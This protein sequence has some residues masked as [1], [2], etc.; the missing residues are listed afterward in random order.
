MPAEPQ[1]PQPPLR[2]QPPKPDA[3]ADL[4]GTP[5]WSERL[6]GPALV[7]FWGDD[8]PQS[9]FRLG[10]REYDWHTHARGQLFCID[11]GLAQLHTPHGSWVLPAHRA[12]WIPPGTA[13]KASVSGALSGWG[14][15]LTPQACRHLPEHPCVFGVSE[16][17]RALVRRA[18]AWQGQQA[19]QRATPAQRRLVGVLLDEI[20]QAPQEALHLPMPQD[21][22]L[23]RLAQA[24]LAAPDAHPTLAA[25]AAQVGLSERS[26][27]RLFHSE[28]GLSFAHWRQQAQL[29]L[30]LQRLA[31]GD[32]VAD[33]AHGLGYASP[34][35][36]IAMFRRAFGQPPGRYMHGGPAGRARGPSETVDGA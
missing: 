6:D 9:A 20:R 5:D 33:I 36:F 14:V 28:T 22:R 13:H 15:L 30:A 17:L 1:P 3:P 11:A 32:A 4:S 12:G 7:A 16:L 35:N 27:R 8:R 24:L 10:T 29:T 21:R 18:T 34:S 2:P 31:R 25:W 19:A 26:A 23:L